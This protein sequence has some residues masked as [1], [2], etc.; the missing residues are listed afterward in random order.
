MQPDA[1]TPAWHALAPEEVLRRLDSDARG[2]SGPE[3]QR[4]LETLGRN[5]LPRPRGPTPL[6]RFLLQNPFYF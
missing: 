1:A 4:R 3:A 2:L 5:T 6:R